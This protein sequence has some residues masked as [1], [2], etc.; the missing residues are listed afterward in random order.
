MRV[1]NHDILTREEE[2]DLIRRYRAGDK[3]AGN[4]VVRC[5]QRFV[6]QQAHRFE[7]SGVAVEDL[8][9]EGSM[10]LL[11]ALD[12]YDPSKGVRFN[13]YAVHWVK[14]SFRKYITATISGVKGGTCRRRELLFTSSRA[15]EPLDAERS[16]V[17][18]LSLDAIIP[19]TE[20]AFVD[21]LESEASPPDACVERQASE[22]QRALIAEVLGT[23]NECDRFI[24]ESRFMAEPAM[25]YKEIG[26]HLGWTGETVRQTA[27]RLKKKLRARLA[28]RLEAA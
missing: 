18:E 22:L 27:F 13:S 17:R 26:K 15:S 14:E 21:I 11:K 9:Q 23:L 7:W 10:A 4:R 25:T 24:A 19:G 16:T 6:M 1:E 3:A 5:N 8:F 20:V 28:A 12:K 2:A